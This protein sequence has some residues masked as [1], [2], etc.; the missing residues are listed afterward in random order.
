MVPCSE[1]VA[2]AMAEAGLLY[3]EAAG[4]QEQSEAERAEAHEQLGPPYVHVL[5]AFLRSPAATKGDWRQNT[6]RS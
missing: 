3:H 1:P 2:E 4:G 5:V 6:F